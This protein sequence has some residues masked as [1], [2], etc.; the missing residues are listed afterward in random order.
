[1]TDKADEIAAL[2]A[3]TVAAMGLELLGI[4]YLPAPGGA[5][6]RLYMD[7][8]LWNR[9][10]MHGLDNVARHFSLDAAREV[11]RRVFFA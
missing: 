6:V 4:E 2:L 3:P 1:M 10:S 8:D 9:L 7:E 11:V 5:V